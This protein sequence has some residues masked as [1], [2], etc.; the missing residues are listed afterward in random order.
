MS[1]PNETL[2]SIKELLGLSTPKEVV[3]EVALADEVVEEVKEE[4]KQ[5]MVQPNYVTEQQL[6]DVKNELF[7]MIQALLE[8]N[9][10]QVKEVPQELA[11]EVKE[12][13]KVELEEVSEIVHSPENEVEKKQ[14]NFSKSVVNM[15]PQERIYAML[16]NK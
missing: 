13:V 5:E 7:L 2:N 15:T 4:S 3:E 8:E 10:K 14:V 9:K 16:N 11:K 12:E 1:K 6:S